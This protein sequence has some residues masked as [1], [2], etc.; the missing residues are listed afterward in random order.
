MVLPPGLFMLF[1]RRRAYKGR[2]NVSPSLI[3]NP[4]LGLS[5]ASL[6]YQGKP[7]KALILLRTAS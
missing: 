2:E 5:L 3:L 7:R 1:Q 4:G 6:G